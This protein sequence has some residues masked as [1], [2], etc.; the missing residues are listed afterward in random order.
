MRMFSLRWLQSLWFS[1][2]LHLLLLPSTSW[3]NRYINCED[4]GY[5]DCG[6]GELGPIGSLVTI[7]LLI[8]FVVAFFRSKQLRKFAFLYA[9][10]LSVFGLGIY[11]IKETFG[12]E[13]VIVAAIAIGVLYWKFEHKLLDSKI[14]NDDEQTPK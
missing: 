13:G 14:L 5:E 11:W 4:M 1:L 6:S 9:V 12:K 3:A 7:G 10:V 2:G 8:L